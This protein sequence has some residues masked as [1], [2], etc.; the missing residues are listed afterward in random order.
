MTS[1]NLSNQNQKTCRQ[2]YTHDPEGKEIVAFETG[3]D[4]DRSATSAS[5]FKLGHKLVMQPDHDLVL[6][7]DSGEAIWRTGTVGKG[8][9][10]ETVYAALDDAGVLHG[11]LSWLIYVF[12]GKG[13]KV[14]RLRLK[15]KT[16]KTRQS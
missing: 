12:L 7:S 5:D 2:V 10:G 15:K 8:M 16:R 6:L 13:F 1:F 4:A 3:T 14:F 9:G 11:A